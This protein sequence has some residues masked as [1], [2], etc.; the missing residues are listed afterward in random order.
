MTRAGSRRRCPVAPDGVGRCGECDPIKVTI[1]AVS[2]S[3]LLVG[4]TKSPSMILAEKEAF[5]PPEAERSQFNQLDADLRAFAQRYFSDPA[6]NVTPLGW[7]PGGFGSSPEECGIAQTK[8]GSFVLTGQAAFPAD[9]DYFWSMVN[10]CSPD[11]PKSTPA[12]MISRKPGLPSKLHHR[13]SHR[14]VLS[15]S[16]II[17]GSTDPSSTEPIY[18]GSFLSNVV[19][20]K[21]VP[22]ETDPLLTTLLLLPFAIIVG[23]WFWVSAWKRKQN[24]SLARL[25]AVVAGGLQKVALDEKLHYPFA[26]RFSG[27]QMIMMDNFGTRLRLLTGRVINGAFSIVADQTIQVDDIVSVELVKNERLSASSTTVARTSGGVGRAV[28]GG[29]IAGPTGAVVGAATARAT[30]TTTRVEQKVYESSEL[31]F[32]LAD[33]D[34]PVLRLLSTNHP[35]WEQWLHRIRGA[36]AQSGRSIVSDATM[37]N[38][39]LPVRGSH[40]PRADYALE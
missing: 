9:D 6:L 1:V 16:T 12:P 8:Y 20:A 10:N 24:A 32:G 19:S 26:F 33:L 35:Q 38:S 18:A 17:N 27:D 4:C 7:S 36:M 22:Q 28:V 14:P 34:A 31:V 3:M 2:L 11:L 30:A 15:N 25:Y 21:D 13:R 29:L 5:R 40:P 39:T 23:L 37:K